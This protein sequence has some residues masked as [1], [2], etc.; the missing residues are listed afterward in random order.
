MTNSQFGGNPP[1]GGKP[2]FGAAIH[3]HWKLFLFEGIVLLVLGAAAIVMPGIAGLAA[4]ILL[5]WLFVIGGAV[6]LFASWAARQTAGFGWAI[7][8]A[9]ITLV[10]GLV[11]LVW[12]V[13]GILS[14]TLVVAAF[15]VMDGAAS[16]MMAFDHRRVQSGAW[17]WLL[18]SALVDILLA[19]LIISGFPGSAEWVI[20]TIVG[21]DFLMGGAA[22]L[23]AALHFRRSTG[24]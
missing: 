19:A 4:T 7:A 9:L 12:P 6:G 16:A 10:A 20:G 2:D 8:S 18:L 5:G 3:A 1:P 22:L 23:A 24:G 14:L 17:G 13:N 21:I 11:L 15:L